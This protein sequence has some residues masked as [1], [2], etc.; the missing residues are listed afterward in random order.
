MKPFLA[1]AGMPLS[2]DRLPPC[3]DLF[4]CFG[5][6]S[7]QRLSVTKNLSV[8]RKRDMK[9]GGTWKTRGRRMRT[10]REVMEEEEEEKGI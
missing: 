5:G 10:S 9:E 7:G 1:V 3:L 6:K 2:V 8:R 4:C